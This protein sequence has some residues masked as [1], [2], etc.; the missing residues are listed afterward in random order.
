MESLREHIFV[1]VGDLDHLVRVA[2]RLLVALVFGAVVGFE[3]EREGKSAGIRTHMLVALGAAL[4]TLVPVETNMEV[5]DLSR[6]I[7]GVVVGIGFLGGGTILQ[8][9]QEH[10][11]RG[12]TS[13]ASIW[14]TASIGMSVGAGFLW[15][16]LIGVVLAWVVLSTMHRVEAWLKPPKS[17]RPGP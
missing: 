6:V 3:R 14:V 2:V 13:A 5:K 17:S 1:Q 11:V 16:A 12:L 10:R 8:L 9:A 7:Q 4:F 15:P